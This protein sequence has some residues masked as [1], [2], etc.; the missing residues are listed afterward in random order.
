[1][2]PESLCAVRNASTN[3]RALLLVA[4]PIRGH[5]TR[6]WIEYYLDKFWDNNATRMSRIWISRFDVDKD[7]DRVSFICVTK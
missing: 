4:Y 1:M 5:G 3:P 2:L 7:K 6:C